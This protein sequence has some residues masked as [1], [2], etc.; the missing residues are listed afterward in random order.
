M[1]SSRH[2][3]SAAVSAFVRWTTTPSSSTDRER[4]MTWTGPIGM[5]RSFSSRPALGPL[6]A[7]AGT[8]RHAARQPCSKRGRHGG[9]PVHAG[10]DELRGCRLRGAGVGGTVD[11][12][13]GGELGRGERGRV[14]AGRARRQPTRAGTWDISST[15]ERV[16]GDVGATDRRDGGA[17]PSRSIAPDPQQS[18]HSCGGSHQSRTERLTAAVRSH[19]TC[20]VRPRCV[21]ARTTC[22]SGAERHRMRTLVRDLAPDPAECG[23]A[24]VPSARPGRER[25]GPKR[26]GDAELV[27]LGVGEGDPVLGPCWP[28]QSLVA[29][30]AIRR[31]TSISRPAASR[32]RWRSRWMRSLTVFG[33]GTCWN[34]SRGPTPAGSRTP[35]R[36]RTPSGRRSR[37]S[38]RRGR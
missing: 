35:P 20:T 11:D 13:V 23:Q 8:A 9:E 14:G 15:S 25:V 17:R 27:A 22:G 16:V 30:S 31:S 36:W 38:P 21:D 5:R 32:P 6:M 10:V 12:A 3:T 19:Q 26:S 29:P 4:I 18:G 24:A 28:S 1:P 37:W 7:S 33:S 2:V 34:S